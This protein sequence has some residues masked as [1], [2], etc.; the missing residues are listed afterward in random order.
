MPQRAGKDDGADPA[1][2]ILT[3]EIDGPDAADSDRLSLDQLLASTDQGWDVE[4]QVRT[5][6]MVAATSQAIIMD[7]GSAARSPE[8]PSARRSKSRPPLP[9]KG[10]PPLPP[11]GTLSPLQPPVRMQSDLLD[12][13]SLVDLLRARVAHLE[14]GDDAIGLSRVHLELAI[15][16][17]TILGDP[18]NALAHG[19][20]ALRAEPGSLAAH[21]LL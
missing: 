13:E 16:S 18:V 1:E 6:Q 7:E 2:A 19:A 8:P 12:P 15:V 3:G 4:A 10:P 5:L 20:A 14:R 9:R 17:E 11:S 21:A